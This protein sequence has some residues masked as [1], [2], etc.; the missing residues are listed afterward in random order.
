MVCRARCRG[1]KHGQDRSI[2]SSIVFY[3]IYAIFKA[4]VLVVLCKFYC[5]HLRKV[6]E[7]QPLY[8]P[9][10]HGA[11]REHHRVFAPQP[12][13]ERSVGA[14][15]RHAVPSTSAET[16]VGAASPKRAAGNSVTPEG[17]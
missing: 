7:G 3:V 14:S 13:H 11:H 6:K 15:T 16:S 8:T 5:H 17:V 12:H 9:Y 4:L 1:L 2:F 10:D